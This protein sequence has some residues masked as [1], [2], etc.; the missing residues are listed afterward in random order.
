M[1]VAQDEIEKASRALDE[2]G[3]D[4]PLREGLD[5]SMPKSSA[6]D[7]EDESDDA[8]DLDPLD[9]TTDEETELPGT[10][11]PKRG[12]GWWGRG[13]TL[14]LHRKG[15]V[16]TFYDGAGLPSPG[17]WAPKQRRLPDDKTAKEIRGIFKKGLAESTDELP[18]GSLKTA[19]AAGKCSETPFPWLA[20]VNLL[21]RIHS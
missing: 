13:P 7:S 21:S 14:G 6:E 12:A 8:T 10:T 11:R 1:I 9:D 3:I 19:L 18:G 5:D 16:T 15:I 17:R 2:K 4:R 20:L